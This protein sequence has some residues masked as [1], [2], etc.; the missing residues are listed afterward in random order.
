[1]A[2]FGMRTESRHDAMCRKETVSSHTV[3]RDAPVPWGLL[4][5]QCRGDLQES[6]AIL[7][8][9]RLGFRGHTLA[10]IRNA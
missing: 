5:P 2:K 6:N 3:D 4:E 8:Q 10:E 9:G 1:M 7:S